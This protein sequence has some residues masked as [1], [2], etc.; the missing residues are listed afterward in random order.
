[1]EDLPTCLDLCSCDL[2]AVDFQI[3]ER[4]AAWNPE[5]LVEQKEGEFQA[6]A[7]LLRRTAVLAQVQPGEVKIISS[8]MG[9]TRQAAII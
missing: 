1:M 2:T 7:S 3:S 6:W 9:A 8:Y 4:N 5:T